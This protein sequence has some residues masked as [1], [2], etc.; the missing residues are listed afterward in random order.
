M[1]DYILIFFS[2]FVTRTQMNGFHV[3]QGVLTPDLAY[4]MTHFD[5]GIFSLAKAAGDSVL[6]WLKSILPSASLPRNIFIIDFA[7]K[8]FPDY[9]KTV[10]GLNSTA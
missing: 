5:S 10:I 7:V 8:M 3:T 9:A 2:F 1:I 4:L 6:S